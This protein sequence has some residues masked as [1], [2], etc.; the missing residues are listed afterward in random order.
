MSRRSSVALLVPPPAAGEVDGLR[1][2]CGDGS[3]GRVP[4]H[5][6]LVPPVNVRDDRFGAALDLLRDA[7][8]ATRP[9][10]VTLGPPATFSPVTPVL[11]LRVSEGGE[12]VRE[13][14]DRVFQP[15]LSRRLTHPFVPHVTLAEELPEERLLAA[16]D[17][18]G[19]YS[20][21]VTFDRV[22]LLEEREG[23]EWVPAAELPFGGPAVVGR[24]GL[25][26]R[27]DVGAVVGP[28]ALAFSERE[29]PLQHLAAHG[30]AGVVPR[31]PLIVT[32]WRE[33]SVVGLAEGW[34]HGGVGW[35]DGL[36]VAAAAR[37]EGIGSHLL[38]A[39]ESACAARGCPRLGLQA[40]A[41]SPAVAF[42][43]ARGWYEEARLTG[44]VHG[45]DRVLLRRDL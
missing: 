21:Q 24:G 40:L 19:D 36:L 45:S 14:R 33:G 32:A 18:L 35:L 27:L 6:T 10:T 23:R 5:L 37:G 15:P 30:R 39:F 28:E 11:Y 20:R 1:R 7:A 17:A 22:H 8:A 38:A 29:W 43:E 25:E 16:V 2:A 42:Y 34:T 3:L 9:F 12:R 31:E 44:W 41:G 13:L 4:P 26:V